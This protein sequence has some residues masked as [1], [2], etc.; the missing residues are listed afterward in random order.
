MTLNTTRNT[1]LNMRSK[2]LLIDD[3]VAFCELCALWLEQAGY[4]VECAHDAA[5]GLALFVDANRN[6]SSQKGFDLVIH[7]L[8]LPPTFRPEE[9]LENLKY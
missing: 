9:S 6:E 7:D 1:P 4:Q 2:I 3:E 8:S 5:S